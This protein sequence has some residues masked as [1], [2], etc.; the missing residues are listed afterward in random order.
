VSALRRIATAV[1]ALALVACGTTPNFVTGY[2]VLAE[3][4]ATPALTGGLVVRPFVD[5]RP[6]RS[7]PTPRRIYWLA[8]PLRLWVGS[9]FQRLDETVRDRSDEIRVNPSHGPGPPMP[10]A[11]AFAA[12]AYPRSIAEAIAADF[13]ARGWF[14]TVRFADAQEAVGNHRYE[15]RGTLRE[16]LLRRSYTSYGLGYPGL[17]LWLTGLPVG[18]SSARVKLELELSDRERGRV[19][20]RAQPGASLSRVF[21]AYEDALGYGSAGLSNLYVTPP[22]PSWGVDSRS[23]FSWHFAAVAQAMRSEVPDIETALGIE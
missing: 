14:D 6:P 5:A 13:G 10:P 2:A 11:P 3:P 1:S 22:H 20:W 4:L 7:D 19:L 9:D 18:R 12:Y 8:L 23:L 15:L 17:P 21:D 16:T